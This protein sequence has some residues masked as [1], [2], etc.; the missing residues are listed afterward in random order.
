MPPRAS[1]LHLRRDVVAAA[2]AAVAVLRLPR[3][4]LE[5]ARSRAETVTAVPRQATATGHVRAAAAVHGAP[6]TV[7]AREARRG[8]AVLIGVAVAMAGERGEGEPGTT[9]RH[10][11]AADGIR[12]V[13]PRGEVEAGGGGVPVIARI[14]PGAKVGAG[15]RGGEGLRGVGV[16]VRVSGAEEGG[17]VSQDGIDEAMQFVGVFRE[18]GIKTG[19]RGPTRSSPFI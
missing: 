2:V 4:P 16:G 1:D 7:A 18:D 3:S 17:D 6:L 9:R 13:E 15:V 11:G 5:L 19:G 12:V 10:R 8:A 14:A